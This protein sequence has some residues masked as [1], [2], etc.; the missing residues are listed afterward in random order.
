LTCSRMY[1]IAES[2][3]VTDANESFVGGF[4]TDEVATAGLVVGVVT[5]TGL[6]AE[7]AVG[8]REGAGLCVGEASADS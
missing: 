1:A 3:F 6:F 8:V 2:L 5:A 4:S 7:G